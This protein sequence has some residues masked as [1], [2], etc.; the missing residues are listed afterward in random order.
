MSTA[1]SS[2]SVAAATEAVPATASEQ[3]KKDGMAGAFEQR[4]DS[5]LSTLQAMLSSLAAKVEALEE[6]AENG[7][8]QQ[9]QKEAVA[10]AYKDITKAE[11]AIGLLEPRLDDLLS[12]L[13]SLLEN[14]GEK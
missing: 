14:D 10:D 1:D 3:R 7:Q 11:N 13:D 12:R 5:Q 6:D 4:L 9:T 8:S 2:N